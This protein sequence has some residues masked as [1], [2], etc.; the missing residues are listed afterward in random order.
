MACRVL[1]DKPSSEPMLFLLIGSI[2]T[3][4]SEI[5]SKYKK[6]YAR[7]LIQQC[8]LQNGSY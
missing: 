6:F 7:K 5:E 1:G 8:R 2:G 4:S 3:H